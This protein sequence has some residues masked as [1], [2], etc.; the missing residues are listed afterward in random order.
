MDQA[1]MPI[2]IEEW[3]V[4]GSPLYKVV[5][6]MWGGYQVTDKLA[7]RFNSTEA[8][9]PVDVCP[10][11]NNNMTWTIWSHAWRPTTPGLYAINL[12]VQDPNIPQR[13]LLRTPPFYLRSVTVAD[14]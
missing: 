2:R 6:V 8:Y 9:V 4:N 13:R 5:G 11:Q 10:P 14:V 1:A 7:I 3:M 12:I